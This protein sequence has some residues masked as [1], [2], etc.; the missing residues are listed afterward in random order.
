MTDKNEMP[1]DEHKFMCLLQKVVEWQ[2]LQPDQTSYDD[3]MDISRKRTG[4]IK[5]LYEFCNRGIPLPD[6]PKEGE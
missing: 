1:I 2:V 3:I 5:E 6:A 4:S